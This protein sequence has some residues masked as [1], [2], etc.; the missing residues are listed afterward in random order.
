MRAAPTI[1]KPAVVRRTIDLLFLG[2]RHLLLWRLLLLGV[3]FGALML[4]SGT[5]AAPLIYTLF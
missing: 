1:A 5:A 3:V 4:L 2:A